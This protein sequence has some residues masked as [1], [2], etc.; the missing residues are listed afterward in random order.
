LR[1]TFDKLQVRSRAQA[2]VMAKPEESFV[3]RVADC[4][5]VPHAGDVRHPTESAS[6]PSHSAEESLWKRGSDR[7]EDR[8]GAALAMVT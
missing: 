7:F 3:R 2:V 1:A 6:I 8:I 5:R 4:R